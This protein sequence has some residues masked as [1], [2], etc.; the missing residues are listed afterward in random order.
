MT[1]EE[2]TSRE[3]NQAFAGLQQFVLTDEAKWRAYYDNDQMYQQKMP[4]SLSNSLTA[5]QQLLVIRTLRENFTTSA[6][7]DSKAKSCQRQGSLGDIL[8]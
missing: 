6:S 1:L 5:F 8:E 3:K 7:P 2:I 4:S